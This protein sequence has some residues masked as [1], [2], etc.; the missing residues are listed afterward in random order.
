MQ[1]AKSLTHRSALFFALAALTLLV[2]TGCGPRLSGGETAQAISEDQAV[3]DLPAFVVDINAGGQPSVGGVPVAQLGTLANQDLSNLE[4]PE[5]WVTYLTTTG[6]QHI[7]IDNSADGLTILVNGQ[8]VPSI[9]WN[10]ESLMTTAATLET[11]GFGVPLLEQLL[12]LVE[13]M[14]A[15]VTIRFPVNEG[16]QEIPLAQMENSVSADEAAAA[17]QAFLEAVA[18]PP[19]IRVVVSYSDDG[20]WVVE[21]LTGQQWQQLTNLPFTAANLEPSLVR[22]ASAAGIQNI[23]LS[24]NPQ[25]IF[26]SINDEDLPY[27]SWEN[28]EVLNTIALADELGLIEQ[29]AAGAGSLDVD[30]LVAT[31]EQLL[32]VVQASD[33]QISV[34]F[35]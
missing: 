1:K 13:Q 14:G 23:T 8:S 11:L 16:V 28:G 29:A 19:T 9:A 26:V 6:V 34:N 35:P 27:L 25:G 30:Q 20:T 12:P 15:G 10:G 24:T 5:E 33:V 7:Q 21:D 17:Q 2:A 18:A 22:G 32:P 31:V 4:L 3:V